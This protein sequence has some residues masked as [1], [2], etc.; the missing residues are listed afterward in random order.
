MTAPVVSRLP[1][2]V[3]TGPT[4]L[5]CAGCGTRVPDDGL[6]FACPAAQAGDDVDHQLRRTIDPTRLTFPSGGEPNPFVRYRTLWHGYHRAV[7]RGATDAEIV[8]EIE[9]LDG[10]VARIDGR[11]FR[12]TPV[13]RHDRLDAELGARASGGVWVKDETGNVSGS[14][15]GRH[16]FGTMLELVLGRPDRRRP[17]AVASCGNAALAAAVVA[18]AAGWPLRVFVPEH[19]DLAVLGRLAE[20][21]ATVTTCERR[22]GETG[23]PPYLRMREALAGGAI[24]FTCQGPENG[25]AIEGG[26]TLGYELAESWR[27][28]GLRP[29]H[30]VVQVGGGAL[31]SSLLQSLAEARALGVIDRLPRVHAVQ[32]AHAAPLG[33]AFEL[34][35]DHLLERIDGPPVGATERLQTAMAAGD[36]DDEVRWIARHRGRFMWPWSP[37]RKSVATG[38][39]DDETYDWLA[40]V[41]GMLATGG[42]PVV[43]DELRLLE[44]DDL[45]RRATGIDVDP[46]GSAGL[47]G[48]LE[49]RH[50]GAIGADET[51][52]V[53]F[54]GIRRSGERP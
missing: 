2:P 3:A 14:H 48:L 19:A 50:R 23:D 27:Q 25:Y 8:R 43:V 1:P 46:T 17:L 13:G 10:A 7:A 4:W 32:T 52:V 53:L 24:P 44:A 47:A 30:L 33:R 9:R 6:V 35:R 49:L 40:V 16:L 34:V 22:A 21:G 39:L 18:R 51:S 5:E 29:D 20:L 11:G 45:A 12:I 41:R 28:A 42:A 38:I 36:L 37:V 54:T 26:L 31:A 15:K